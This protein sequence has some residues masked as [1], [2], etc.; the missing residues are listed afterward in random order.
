MIQPGKIKFE[1]MIQPGEIG[2]GLMIQPGEI[3]LRVVRAA[4][5]GRQKPRPA[6]YL[7]QFCIGKCYARMI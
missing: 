5:A 6:E 2:S 3:T 4:F 7:A 1:L